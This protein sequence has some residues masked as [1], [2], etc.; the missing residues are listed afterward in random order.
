MKSSHIFLLTTFAAVIAALSPAAGQQD[1]A[2]SAGNGPLRTLPHGTYSCA[3]PGDAGGSAF[4]RVESEDFR[5]IPASRYVTSEGEGV[6]ILRGRELTFT[7]GPKKDER[8]KRVGD[9][10]LRKIDGDGAAT[11]LLCTR[12]G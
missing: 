8:Y 11:E 4:V 2:V 3:L 6:Y 9:N 7:R 1:S 12:I 5:I 10:Q